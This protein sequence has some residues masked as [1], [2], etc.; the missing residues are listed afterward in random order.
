MEQASPLADLMP[1]RKGSTGFVKA[2]ILLLMGRL[3]ECAEWCRRTEVDV[4]I[5]PIAEI[6]ARHGMPCPTVRKLVDLI[7]EVEDG[8]RK[9]SDD[10]LLELLH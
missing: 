4:Q 10:N 2:E 9:L 8:K 7:H 1:Y 6:G 3:A 5:M